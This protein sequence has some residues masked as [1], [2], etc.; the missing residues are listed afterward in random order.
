MKIPGFVIAKRIYGTSPT[1]FRPILYLRSATES[2][3]IYTTFEIAI[4]SYADVIRY[5]LSFN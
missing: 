4:G 5:R 2:L 1:E 3:T